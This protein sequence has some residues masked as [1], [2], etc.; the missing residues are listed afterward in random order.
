MYFKD[1]EIWKEAVNLSLEIYSITQSFPKE[2]QYGIISQMRR[3]AISIPSNIAEGS[4]RK[5]DRDTLRF[6]EIAI[7]SIAELE[8][9]VIISN[10]LGYI[11]NIDNITAK[12]NKLYVL[13]KDFKQYLEKT[14][15][16][17]EH[18]EFKELS[19]LTT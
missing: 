18:S 11:S 7:G 6:V 4:V 13:T 8:T 3:C 14:D 16:Y 19:V 1:L 17:Y 5:S 2:E 15:K 12:I 9:Q 10:K